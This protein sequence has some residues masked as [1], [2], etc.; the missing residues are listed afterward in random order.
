MNPGLHENGRLVAVLAGG[1]GGAA[2]STAGL[3]LPLPGAGLPKWPSLPPGDGGAHQRHGSP[4]HK[5][6]PYRSAM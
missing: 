4:Q 5:R 3:A 1:A 2:V 6:I